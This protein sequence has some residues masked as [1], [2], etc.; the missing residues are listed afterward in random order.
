VVQ[1]PFPKTFEQANP[2][3]SIFG[4]CFAHTSRAALAVLK[5]AKDRTRISGILCTLNLGEV[6]AAAEKRCAMLLHKTEAGERIVRLDALRTNKLMKK[7]L[8]QKRVFAEAQEAHEARTWTDGVHFSK[9]VK[10]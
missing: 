6:F 7:T 5:E 2:G 1:T 8:F 3:P 10:R 4:L 9:R